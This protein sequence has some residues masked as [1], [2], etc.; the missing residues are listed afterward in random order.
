[1]NVYKK[2]DFKEG[3]KKIVAKFGMEMPKPPKGTWEKL[4]KKGL[5]PAAALTK[6]SNMTEKKVSGIK[7]VGYRL[8]LKK[9]FDDMDE[10]EIK[11]RLSDA[12]GGESTSLSILKVLVD[13]MDEEEI[14]R[15][16]SDARGGEPTPPSLLKKL[17]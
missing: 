11:R 6:A 10:E 15:R 5:T 12:K 7:D 13:D 1:M 16:L 4:R 8:L 2:E 17:L 3:V 9:I 14:K